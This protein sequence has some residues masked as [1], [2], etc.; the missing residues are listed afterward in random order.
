MS[1]ANKETPTTRIGYIEYCNFCGEAAKEDQTWDEY[2]KTTT[3]YCDCESA[4]QWTK[5]TEDYKKALSKISY[6]KNL[7]KHFR[8]LEYQNELTHLKSRYRND[9]GD[10]LEDLPE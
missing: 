5:A 3:W 2:E 8:T 7:S 9:F 10:K 4:G 1:R 6:K